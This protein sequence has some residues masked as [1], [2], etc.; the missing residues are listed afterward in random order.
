MTEIRSR[1]KILD[2]I[3]KIRSYSVRLGN[4]EDILKDE[5]KDVTE[6]AKDEIEKR[7]WKLIKELSKLT[8]ET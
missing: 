4:L 7:G 3:N 2:K 1:N 8:S 5:D 6:T